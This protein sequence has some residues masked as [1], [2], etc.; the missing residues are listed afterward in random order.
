MPEQR[1]WK[2]LDPTAPIESDTLKREIPIAPRLREVDGKTVGFLSNM[3]PSVRPTFQR[4]I[5]VA[6]ERHHVA[7]SVFKEHPNASSA[8]PQSQ[9]QEL[10][11]QA[12][13]VVVGLAN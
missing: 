9:L 12:D 3:W 10:A 11:T 8:A 4:F 6:K 5:E 1:T 13:A 7:H 2:I